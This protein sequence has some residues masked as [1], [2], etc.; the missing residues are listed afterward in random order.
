MKTTIPNEQMQILDGLVISDG[1]LEKTSPKTRNS[2]ICFAVKHKDFL[3]KIVEYLPSIRWSEIK[4]R[5]VFD[6]RTKK[7]HISNR[8]RSKNYEFCTN[9]RK[10]WYRSGKVEE[11]R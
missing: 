3:E 9:Q 7:H 1:S 4:T 5:K 6:K 2:R 8:L 11:C 10:R